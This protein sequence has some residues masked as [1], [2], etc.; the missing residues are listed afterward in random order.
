MGKRTEESRLR[1][2]NTSLL[3]RHPLLV[4]LEG[5]ES[6]GHLGHDTGDDGTET[7]VETKRSLALHDFS[8]GGD[9]TSRFDL[10]CTLKADL[11]V[12]QHL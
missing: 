4:C 11:V 9:E 5:S 6:N 3:V 10:R 12:D 1:A 8:A 2:D 7:L